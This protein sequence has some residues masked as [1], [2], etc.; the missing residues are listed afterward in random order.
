M[1]RTELH[2]PS[3][4]HKLLITYVCSYTFIYPIQIPELVQPYLYST[5]QFKCIARIHLLA[6]VGRTP[7]IKHKMGAHVQGLAVLVHHFRAVCTRVLEFMLRVLDAH[8][9]V[10]C[11]S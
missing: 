2:P 7:F 10:M 6:R 3:P 8:E 5:A 1:Q 4:A 9:P 11:S